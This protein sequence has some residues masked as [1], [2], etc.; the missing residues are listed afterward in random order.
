MFLPWPFSWPRRKDATEGDGAG[1]GY[2]PAL[3]VP[4]IGGTILEAV[5]EKGAKERIWVRLLNADHEFRMKLWSK[6]NTTTGKSESL[7]PKTT[8]QV[9]EDNFGLYSCDVLDPDLKIPLDMVN[10]Y[11][12]L[13]VEMRK[14]GY[15]DGVNLFGFGYDFR[16]SNRLEETMTRLLQ[17]LQQVHEQTGRKVDVISHSMGGLVIKCFLSL[18]KEEFEKHVN[19]WI[20]IASPFRGAPGF[21][22]DCLLTGVEFLKGWERDLFVAKWSMHQLLVECP[23]IYE[24]MAEYEFEWTQ[25]PELRIVRVASEGASAEDGDGGAGAGKLIMEKHTKREQVLQVLE[26]AMKKNTVD[27]NG[28]LVPLPLSKAIV[29]VAADTRRVLNK[30]ELPEGCKFYN[31]Y[32]TCLDT[33]YHTKYGSEKAPL[34]HL[35]EI[36]HTEAE[37]EYVEGDGTVPSESSQA[38]GLSA[39]WRIGVP[40]EH[41][42]LLR[43]PRVFRMLKHFL[44]AG[45]SDPL[46]DPVTDCVLV[47]TKEELASSMLAEQEEVLVACAGGGVA[48]TA[49]AQ[50]ISV[51][52]VATS[53]SAETAAEEKVTTKTELQSVI[54]VQQPPSAPAAASDAMSVGSSQQFRVSTCTLK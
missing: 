5:D 6:Y 24:M 35:H 2:H 51:S 47:P 1:E 33:P 49:Q 28:T 39:M 32:G 15:K 10:Y 46:Y 42:G 38:D 12:N 25:V 19:K 27:V 34:K 44:S 4:G 52:E 45:E 20:T 17:K 3:L 30:A 29:E 9:P 37:F 21:I 26:A 23:A 14:W 53:L 40:G 48:Q 18:H 31:I 43:D 7:N 36:L 22:M 54:E 8:I 13:I 50:C 11:H 16:Q 41:R